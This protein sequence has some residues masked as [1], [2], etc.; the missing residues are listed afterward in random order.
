LDYACGWGNL[1]VSLARS[2]KEVHGIDL[3]LQ[4]ARFAKRHAE[5]RG[6]KNLKWVVGGDA[7]KLPFPDGY[8]DV[9]ILNGI[10][11]WIPTSRD[12][13]KSPTEAQLIFLRELARITSPEGMICLAIENRIG[14]KYFLGSKDE[15]SRLRYMTILPRWLADVY[16]SRK[17]GKPFREYTHT[18]GGYRNLLGAAGFPN[19]E[20]YIPFP[21]YRHFD[22]LLPYRSPKGVFDFLGKRRKIT[23]LNA[24]VTAQAPQF[25]NAFVVLAGKTQWQKVSSAADQ[26]ARSFPPQKRE[27]V[28][29]WKVLGTGSVLS[30]GQKAANGDPVV[31]KV[32]LTVRGQTSNEAALRN[33]KEL[34]SRK[35]TPG[36]LKE[37]I[38]TPGERSELDGFTCF[39]QSRLPGVE[40]MQLA[41]RPELKDKIFNATAR[42][43][44]RLHKDTAQQTNITEAVFN[45]AIL[46][47]IDLGL[48][49]LEESGAPAER[50]RLEAAIRRSL[51]GQSMPL[52]LNHGDYWMKNVLFDKSTNEP[53]AIIDWDRMQFPGPAVTDLLNL[54][55]MSEKRPGKNGFLETFKKVR[56]RI[57]PDRR[58]G[59]V[60]EYFEAIPLSNGL[61]NALTAV[62]F[63]QRLPEEKQFAASVDIE[64]AQRL[65][66]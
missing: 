57:E 45:N 16:S 44:I 17:R 4:R 10:L 54:L 48:K 2:A 21:S 15:H 60:A 20:A 27:T 18:I 12:L 31:V 6:L 52:V 13:D 39:V 55:L 47:T 26:L 61:L 9:V 65:L 62:Y 32:P 30:Y 56:Q 14:F 53:T 25:A 33:L 66:D 40:G 11:E 41:L 34:H 51:V 5:Y 23:H 7:Q 36:W 35:E 50:Q 1:S 38:A 59:I 63:L 49:L 19:S 3:S 29:P 42:L 43:L 8:F 58:T 64:F 22:I 37:M 46:P 28:R 24:A